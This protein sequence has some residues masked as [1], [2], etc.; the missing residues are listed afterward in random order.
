MINIL[1]L[2]IVVYGRTAL[3][4]MEKTVMIQE[5]TRGKMKKEM[6]EKASISS[7][8]RGDNGIGEENTGSGQEE[9]GIHTC[10]VR[11]LS[12]HFLLATHGGGVLPE[13]ARL[14]YRKPLRFVRTFGSFRRV[15]SAAPP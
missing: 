3:E 14:L 4:K 2:R 15:E 13:V 5:C 7:I 9:G 11:R 8:R 12:E 10:R 6:R 1:D